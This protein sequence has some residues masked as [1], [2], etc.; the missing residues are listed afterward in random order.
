M[1]PE[2]RLASSLIPGKHETRSS[3]SA[4]GG[5]AAQPRGDQLPQPDSIAE[6]DEEEKE[7]HLEE[8][9]SRLSEQPP[10]PVVPPTS[11]VQLG[12][13]SGHFRWA[14]DLG[15]TEPFWRGWFENLSAGFLAVPAAK[16]LLLAGVDRLDRDL[17]VGQMQVS[18]CSQGFLYSVGCW[19][20]CCES[21]FG[22]FVDS[23]HKC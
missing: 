22:S 7:D 5:D 3:S 11:V 20:Q 17:T 4:A 2:G 9:E 23:Q 21:V 18:Q 1:D 15:G 12:S 6:V 10:R 14:V 19:G 16:L 13:G 8:K